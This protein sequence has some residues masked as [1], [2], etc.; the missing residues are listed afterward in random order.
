MPCGSGTQTVSRC[1]EMHVPPTAPK[2]GDL[3]GRG[4]RGQ[5]EHR[6]SLLHTPVQV[7]RGRELTYQEVPGRLQRARR[8]ELQAVQ[9]ASGGAPGRGPRVQEQNKAAQ[10]TEV[11]WSAVRDDL[12]V[13]LENKHSL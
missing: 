5:H 12:V 7:P 4:S 11:D 3:S 8:E 1:R 2:Q 6:A 13:S 10:H 9:G